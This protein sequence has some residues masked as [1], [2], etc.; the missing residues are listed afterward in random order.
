MSIVSLC[1]RQILDRRPQACDTK[2]CSSEASTLGAAS[3]PCCCPLHSHESP[4]PCSPFPVLPPPSFPFQNTLAV[5][6]KNTGGGGTLTTR[7]LTI[8]ATWQPYRD[9]LGKL[10]S[11]S[12]TTEVTLLQSHPPSPHTIS[13]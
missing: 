9:E 8:A 4:I 1:W 11:A 2:P 5:I 12:Y 3:L 7:L 10:V 6:N 13:L